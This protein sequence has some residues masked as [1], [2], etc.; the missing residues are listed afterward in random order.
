MSGQGH[1]RLINAR[2]S[3]YGRRVAI[4]L[5]EKGL[6]YEVTYDVPWGPGTCTPEYSPFQQLPILITPDGQSLYESG[7]ILEWLEAKHPVPP[8]LPAAVDPRLE[9]RHRQM[10]GERLMDF[11]QALVFEHNRPEP[12]PA[13][14]ERQ[15]L[16][17]EGGLDAL[18]K[19][20]AN[21]DATAQFD[22]G[23]LAIATT[24]LLF[25]FI[26]PAGLA[27]DL[28]Q[29]RW[30]GRVPNLAAMADRL[31]QR[32]SFMATRPQSMTVDLK[33]TVGA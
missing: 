2:P 29:L 11:V 7:Y 32:P 24:V 12:S 16:K 8:L 4:V 6:D 33:A 21:R 17:V 19:I 31:D 23:D 1:F 3:P 26:V 9:A 28:P 20:Y 25:D 13:W 10:L 5:I 14:V 27:P 22:L 30:R 15:R 18:E